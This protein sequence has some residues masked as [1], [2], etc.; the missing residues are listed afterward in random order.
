MEDWSVRP[1]PDP[2]L[3]LSDA[4]LWRSRGLR[5]VEVSRDGSRVAVAGLAPEIDAL[6]VPVVSAAKAAGTVMLAGGDEGLAQRLGI[7]R[8]LP[9]GP[10]LAGHVHDLQA[11]GHCVA[12]VSKNA[13]HALAQ[14]DIGVGVV[15][16]AAEEPGHVV[17]WDAD[18]AGELNGV[19]LFLRCLPRAR[20]NSAN[21]VRLGAAGACVGT[22]L[23]VAGPAATALRRAQ[24]A[25]AAVSLGAIVLG[26]WD[27]QNAGR[28]STPARADSTPWHAMSAREVLAR[29]RSSSEGIGEQEAGRRRAQAV[30]EEAEGPHSLARATLEELANPLT[31]ALATGAGISALVGSVLDAVL[32]SGVMVINAFLGGVQRFKADRALLS[33][34]ESTEVLV[35]LRRPGGVVETTKAD[36]A[37]GDVIELR[38]G[39][40][41]PRTPASSRPSGW[42]WTSRRSPAS[43]SSSRRR[44][45]RPWRRPSPTAARWST[46][47]PRSRR[48]AAGRWSS[49]P[50]T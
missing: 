35:R 26:E 33:L 2:D 46:R 4:D 3:L 16:P 25:S 47:E 31:P 20:G 34:T 40:P 21:A 9:G 28:V 8:T 37:P 15:D 6:A 38:A 39:T 7:V 45:R 1:L 43:R 22:L 30:P 48:A 27:G 49:R 32:I 12:V 42:R 18:I 44:P 36:L 41:C 11:A 17:P 10:E 24:L 19:H 13:W 29:L 14:A 5:A 23:A 50:A